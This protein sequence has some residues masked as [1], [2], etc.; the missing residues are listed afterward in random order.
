MKNGRSAT[1][2]VC[3]VCDNKIF[4]VRNAR[5]E[6]AFQTEARY[7]SF[8]FSPPL[9]SGLSLGVPHC[10]PPATAKGICPINRG[11]RVCMI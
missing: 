7:P 2:G 8:A 9:L 4:R 10:Y 1:Q 5:Q 3:P 6:V 11:Y